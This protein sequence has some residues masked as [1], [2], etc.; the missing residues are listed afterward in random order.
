MIKSGLLRFGMSESRIFFIYYMENFFKEKNLK[1]QLEYII[2]LKKSFLR[3]LYTATGFYDKTKNTNIN[4][5]RTGWVWEDSLRNLENDSDTII[6]TKY[7]NIMLEL[8]SEKHEYLNLL[9]PQ[10]YFPNYKNAYIWFIEKNNKDNSLKDKYHYY[11]TIKNNNIL[12]ISA[13]TELI[14]QQIESGNFYK[15]VEYL[16]PDE[17]NYSINKIQYLKSKYTYFNDGPD[18][19]IFETFEKYIQEL[20]NYQNDY[21]IVLISCGAYGPLFYKYFRKQG[22]IPIIMGGDIQPFFGILNQR[23]KSHNPKALSLYWEYNDMNYLNPYLIHEIDEKYKPKNY[24]QIED[25]CF[26]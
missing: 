20:Q 24:K 1:P 14:Q 25:G 10:D 22:K 23:I 21:N 11:E 16:Y 13:F 12:I 26:W 18:N 4:T 6:F 3:W 2:A 15:I 8:L 9:V 19:N 17:K 5:K 7:M